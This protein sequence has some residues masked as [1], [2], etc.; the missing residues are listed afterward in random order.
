MEILKKKS[1]M[2]IS[3]DYITFK[4][5]KFKKNYGKLMLIDQADYG[6]QQIFFDDNADAP[7]FICPSLSFIGMR[8]AM[9]M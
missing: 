4:N 7:Y 2:G 3:D 1:S 9:W 5:N 6:T 8:T